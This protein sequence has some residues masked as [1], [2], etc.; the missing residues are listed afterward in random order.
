MQ[1]YAA[2]T[3]VLTLAHKQLRKNYMDLAANSLPNSESVL[4][5]GIDHIKTKQLVS[6]LDK[7]M[8]E[9][10]QLDEST[11]VFQSGSGYTG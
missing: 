4:P 11:I 10:L 2:Y 8:I 6:Y 9:R 5:M 3:N 7:E 1:T